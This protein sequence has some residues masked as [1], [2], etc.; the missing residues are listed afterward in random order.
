VPG[1]KQSSSRRC[2]HR[3]C[4]RCSVGMA[5]SDTRLCCCI[6]WTA[7]SCV[8]SSPGPLCTHSICTHSICTHSIY[9]HS[10]CTHS[11]PRWKSCC[12]R[13]VSASRR[14]QAICWWHLDRAA[15]SETCRKAGQPWLCPK[16]SPTRTGGAPVAAQKGQ[17]TWE[18]KNFL[19][20]HFKGQGPDSRFTGG[21]N[22]PSPLPPVPVPVYTVLSIHILREQSSPLVCVFAVVNRSA[23]LGQ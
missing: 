18:K 22:F 8:L 12:R 7:T 1:A 21:S 17:K 10:I 14:K 15:S 13:R 9:T 2:V 11:L 19:D 6:Y 20:I 3:A 16:K 23:T 5:G 4:S